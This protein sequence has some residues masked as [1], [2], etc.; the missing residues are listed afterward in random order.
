[1]TLSLVCWYVSKGQTRRDPPAADVVRA[2]V[3]NSQHLEPSHN[4]KDIIKQYQ[5]N[6]V[7][8]TE[9]PRWEINIFRSKSQ[10]HI[11][12]NEWPELKTDT[13]LTNVLFDLA[14]KHW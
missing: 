9:I 13:Q 11:F 3:S 7:K 6:P 2:T 10:F 4:I 8:P 5:A 14:T 12:N 1:M